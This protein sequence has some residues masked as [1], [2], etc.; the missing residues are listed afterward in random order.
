MT[1]IHNP[2]ADAR[3][4]I[5]ADLEAFFA[6]GGKVKTLPAYYEAQAPS[7]Q[8]PSQ[9]FN[10]SLFNPANAKKPKKAPVQNKKIKTILAVK[11]CNKTGLHHVYDGAKKVSTGFYCESV[12]NLHR[13]TL[14]NKVNKGV[15]LNA[16]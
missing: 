9:Q 5:H 10:R 7:E 1:P 13:T 4:Q 11:F 16:K 12:A 2:T 6:S 8:K 15:P 3:Q 14:Q